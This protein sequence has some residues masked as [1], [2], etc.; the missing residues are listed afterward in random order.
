MKFHI[1]DLWASMVL[2]TEM[3]LL[4]NASLPICYF[5]L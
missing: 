4:R 5:S 1:P 3:K 2:D